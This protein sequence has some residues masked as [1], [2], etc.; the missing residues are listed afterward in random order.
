MTTGIRSA[1]ASGAL[2]IGGVD[3]VT[4]DAGGINGNVNPSSLNSGQL[5]G[6]RNKIINGDMSV[7]QVNGTTEQTPLSSS[8]I[9]DQYLYVTSVAS[10]F[11]IKQDT[12]DVPAGFKYAQK[13]TVAIQAPPAASD[14]FAIRQPIEGQ[15]LINFQ[16]GTATAATLAISLVVKGSI[17][18]TYSVAIW[19]A[20]AGRSY[21]GTIAVTNVW[22]RQ[23]VVLV[24]DLSGTYA[25]DT[26]VGVWLCLDLGSGSNFNATAGVWNAT[27]KF[28]TAGSVVFGNQAVNST[29][30]FTGLQFEQV[31]AGATQG[32]AFEYV[33]Y[34]TQL[35]W[36][37]R[38]V[39]P[40]SAAT[41]YPGQAFSATSAN[42]ITTGVPM[43]GG[44][45]LSASSGSFT[46]NAAGVNQ[47][48]TTLAISNGGISI[49]GTTYLYTSTAT[50]LAAGNATL[51]TP[52]ANLFI[53]AQM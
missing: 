45:T 36:C 44:V 42:W 17:A 7:S 31:S 4:Y 24:G 26:T 2:Q 11:K 35:A 12:V 1:T 18:G 23:T 19:N 9:L 46:S 27:T 40:L 16:L 5:S 53:L 28:N 48:I 10:K 29:F 21:V 47:A 13:I 14:Q 32:T 30:S 49:D 41:N 22:A 8:Y 52:A 51:L 39:R 6:F 34:A 25:N 50:G 15:N 38:Y 43:R 3:A 33:P 20:S 37:Q